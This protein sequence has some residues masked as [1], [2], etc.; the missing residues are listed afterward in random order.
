MKPLFLLLVLA[1]APEPCAAQLEIAF[2][3]EDAERLAQLN[4]SRVLAAEQD[5]IIAAE[6]V[7]E[8][9]YLFLPEF[10]L[11]A[12]AT[13]Y[14][15][16]YPFSLS[17]DFRNILLFPNSPNPYGHKTDNLY[18]GRGYMHLSLYEGRRTINTLRLAQALQKQASSAL[19][20][21]K[22]DLQLS[23]KEVFYRL[24][25]AQERLLAI[26]QYR[27]SVEDAIGSSRLDAWE[28]IEGEA[29]QS[30]AR[31]KL[32]EAEHALNLARL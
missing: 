32:S 30:V 8:A 3:L 26:A 11:Q 7:R 28:R 6:R 4:D 18:S 19:E 16:R 10:G 15:A 12:S 2:T 31:A 24:L 22:M 17:G 9:R 21:V 5:K 29:R 13:K 1:G 23:V 25:L 14:E 20:S 27:R